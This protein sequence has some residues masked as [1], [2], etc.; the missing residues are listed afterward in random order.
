MDTM[1]VALTTKTL[2]SFFTPSF[3]KLSRIHDLDA[4]LIINDQAHWEDSSYQTTARAVRELRVV[5]DFTRRGMAL[6]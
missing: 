5:N 6:M 1:S 3:K 2:A 4:G